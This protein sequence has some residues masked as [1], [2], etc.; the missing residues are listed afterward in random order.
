[1]AAS[2]AVPRHCPGNA[3]YNE[4]MNRQ[5]APIKAWTILPTLLLVIFLIIATPAR[6]ATSDPI[7]PQLCPL[8]KIHL[9]VGTAP[10]FYGL[11]LPTLTYMEAQTTLFPQSN[12]HVCGG[13]LFRPEQ[14]ATVLYCPLCRKREAQWE[15]A[16][17]VN[18]KQMDEQ[19]YHQFDLKM[20]A[21][22]Q[23]YCRLSGM[24]PEQAQRIPIWRLP[25]LLDNLRKARLAHAQHRKTAP[26]KLASS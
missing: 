19:A 21:V 1:M 4:S 23:E 3:R 6:D 8:H 7:A 16:Y 24:R 25:M 22:R 18:K 10:I 14:T 11:I 15:A 5:N 20:Q 12:S 26:A 2:C 9:R 17:A 13:C